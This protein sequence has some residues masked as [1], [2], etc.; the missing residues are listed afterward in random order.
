MKR[1]QPPTKRIMAIIIASSLLMILVYFGLVFLVWKLS[2]WPIEMIS[3]GMA[4]LLLIEIGV[5][6][7]LLNKSRFKGELDQFEKVE[8]DKEKKSMGKDEKPGL[9]GIAL[10]IPLAFFGI[11]AYGFEKIEAGQ[12]LSQYMPEIAYIL[13]MLACT[14][15]LAVLV[16]NVW[17]GRVFTKVNV[18]ILYTISGIIIMSPLLQ[19]KF[20]GETPM[21]PNDSMI[22]VYLLISSIL[23]FAAQ[24]IEV[25]VK[26]RNDQDLIV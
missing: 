19:F 8:A 3:V 7:T 23:F 11:T 12:P 18:E 14:V 22:M 13:T 15:L 21:V 17:K 9:V 26:V 25:G 20:L 6:L 1:N 5:V 4:P 24:I 10:I 16:F 2:G